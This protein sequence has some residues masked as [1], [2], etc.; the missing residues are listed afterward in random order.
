M[1]LLST[2]VVLLAPGSL[3]FA[4]RRCCVP[5]MLLRL[6]QNGTLVPLL[7]PSGL[8]AP[9]VRVVYV[10]IQTLLTIETSRKHCHETEFRN[11]QNYHKYPGY[12]IEPA[13]RLVTD[14][15]E[16]TRL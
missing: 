8:L 4:K 1:I 10:K 11:D 7:W 2:F 5:E 9:C 12:S 6:A 15:M 13:P 3:A 14:M 16:D